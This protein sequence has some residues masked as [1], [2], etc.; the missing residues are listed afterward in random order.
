MLSRG[1]EESHVNCLH[2]VKPIAD[3]VAFTDIDDILMPVDPLKVRP[4]INVE[5]LHNLFN[6]HPRA[7]SFLFEHRDVQFVLPPEERVD[8]RPNSLALF[9]FEF[10][11]NSQWKTSCKVWRMKTRV[12]VNASKTSGNDSK[13][14]QQHAI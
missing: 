2:F 11:H 10:L 4:N 5:L 12:V 14:I 1:I 8:G 13:Q 3:M 6:E 9:N 7:G